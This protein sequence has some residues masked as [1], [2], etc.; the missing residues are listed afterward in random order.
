MYEPRYLT[1]MRA[2]IDQRCTNSRRQVAMAIKFCAVAPN[3]CGASL[4]K[5]LHVTFLMLRFLRWLVDF[6]KLLYP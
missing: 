2:H 3:I 6:G 4:W 1:L 5:L